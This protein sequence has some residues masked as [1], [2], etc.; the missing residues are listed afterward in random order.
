MQPRH[1]IRVTAKLANVP[2]QFLRTLS[3]RR[4]QWLPGR[5]SWIC[6]AR[7]AGASPRRSQFARDSA[8]SANLIFGPRDPHL[9]LSLQHKATFAN[10]GAESR[11]SETN[12]AMWEYL[13]RGCCRPQRVTDNSR[14][15]NRSRPEVKRRAAIARGPSSLRSPLVSYPADPPLPLSES[16]PP[17]C[18]DSESPAPPEEAV[19]FA[20]ARGFGWCQRDPGR[21][22]TLVDPASP[23]AAPDPSLEVESP[24]FVSRRGP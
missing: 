6:R 13:V 17:E 23:V 20:V 11:I 5:Q 8:F 19:A 3:T 7:P 1:I 21:D 12:P 14:A 22:F 24:S 4:T 16:P 15:G 18:D 9:S 10:S 2:A